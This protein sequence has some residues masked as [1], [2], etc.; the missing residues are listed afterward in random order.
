MKKTNTLVFLIGL[1]LPPSFWGNGE[2]TNWSLGEQTVLRNSKYG[3]LNDLTLSRT[4]AIKGRTT[5]FIKTS[6]LA[7]SNCFA[8]KGNGISDGRQLVEL[9][10]ISGNSNA[11]RTIFDNYNKL[12]GN[13]NT[14]NRKWNGIWNLALLL[15]DD[16]WFNANFNYGRV[17]KVHSSLKP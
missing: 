12:I 1:L 17:F 10:K 11:F 7:F 4:N 14:R 13:Q 5:I 3:C 9:D 15:V 2:T 8:P 16:Y 6:L